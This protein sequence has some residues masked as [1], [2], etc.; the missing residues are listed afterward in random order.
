MRSRSEIIALAIGLMAILS[1]HQGLAQTAPANVSATPPANAAGAEQQAAEGYILGPD[2]V[3]E[4]EVLG[5]TDFRVRAKVGAD[6]KIQVPFLGDV[7]AANRTPKELGEQIAKA[8]EA[9]GYF[10]HPVM[11]VEVVAFAS[12]YVTVLGSVG[13]PGLVPINRPYRLSE[14]MARVGGIRGDGA[15]HVIL[16]SEGG[17]EREISM[18]AMATGGA[19]EDPMVQAGDKIYVPQAEMF[20]ISGQV[21]SP[22]TYPLGSDMTFRMAIARG[23]G[24]TEMGTDRRVKVTRGGQEIKKVD[25]DAKIQPGDIIVVGE[26]LF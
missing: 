11:R 21:R 25:L 1:P 9:G 13:A 23:G 14:I 12:R 2:D 20:Y 18:E 26:R 6:G 24:L 7:E 22:G 4:V 17:Q 8:L 3:V 10:S 5:R 16:R 19:S 15:D